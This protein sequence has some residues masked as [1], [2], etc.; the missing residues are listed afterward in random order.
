MDRP[1]TQLRQLLAGRGCI[2][3]PGVA[4][5]SGLPENQRTSR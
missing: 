2:V 4:D 1:A 3:L 5:A